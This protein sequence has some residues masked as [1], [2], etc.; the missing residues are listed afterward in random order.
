M[1]KKIVNIK[2]K[3]LFQ[4]YYQI[5][6]K[7]KEYIIL[8]QVGEFYQ[9]YYYDAEI[10]SKLFGLQLVKRSVGNNFLIPMCGIPRG[11]IINYIKPL[12]ENGYPVIIC[13]QVVGS[14]TKDKIVE[15]KI[16]ETYEPERNR[17]DI[18]E[19][20]ERYYQEYIANYDEDKIEKIS[21]KSQGILQELSTLKI[22][23]IT[24][25]EA[26]VILYQ[27]KEKYGKKL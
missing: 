20:W 15:R 8:F 7:K 6:E 17:K 10:V 4:Q 14:Y 1:R 5:K 25:M 16:V 21:S 2:Y 26:L 22:E 3:P 27:W 18:T 11:H 19:D 12:S 23:N 9:V 24:P 13:D